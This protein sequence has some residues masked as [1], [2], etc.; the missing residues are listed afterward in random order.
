MRVTPEQVQTAIAMRADGYKWREVAAELGCTISTISSAVSNANDPSRAAARRDRWRDR[1]CA[2]GVCK[3]CGKET[4]AQR[5]GEAPPERCRPCYRDHVTAQTRTRI[6]DAIQA[7][8]AKYGETP[9]A[10]DWLLHAVRDRSG[11]NADGAPFTSEV[12]RAFGSWNAAITAAGFEPREKSKR[13]RQKYVTDRSAPQ[14]GRQ[15][16]AAG[17]ASG[18]ASRGL[19]TKHYSAMRRDET[20]AAA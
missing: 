2:Q 5:A 17:C 3:S 20:R 7:W 19:C 13:G 1:N 15:C 16:S 4:T 18:A 9:S 12:Q 10:R 14:Q 6:I 11:A 8:H